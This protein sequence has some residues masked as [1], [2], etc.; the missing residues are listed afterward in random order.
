MP[1][2]YSV[3][4]QALAGAVAQLMTLVIERE[5]L[6]RERA[7]AQASALALRESNRRLDEFMSIAS[8]E[9][10]TPLT[11]IK[12]NVQLARRRAARTVERARRPAR[13]TPPRSRRCTPC[14]CAPT[15]RSTGRS[16][17]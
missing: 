4:E 6:V 8:H 14:S 11:T 15:R 10:K 2:E 7:E 9:L 17:W 3:S 16:A 12:A 1:H 5:R 13:T